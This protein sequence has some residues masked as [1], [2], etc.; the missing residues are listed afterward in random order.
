MAE[1]VKVC[2]PMPSLAHGDIAER[3]RPEPRINM[4]SDRAAAPA[5]P[6][7]IAPQLT[8]LVEAR[9]GRAGNLSTSDR[10]AVFA[11]VSARKA[12]GMAMVDAS[13]K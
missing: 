12:V 1:M 2:M 4:I 3:P 11:V 7:K 6:A 8:P 5:A 13:E 9:E 10:C